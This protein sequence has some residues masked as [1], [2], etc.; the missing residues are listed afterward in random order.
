MLRPLSSKLRLQFSRF[1]RLAILNSGLDPDKD[2]IMEAACIVTEADLSE[3]A[4]LEKI[5][6]HQPSFILNGTQ[7][8]MTSKVVGKVASR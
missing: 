2:T 5:V 4:R 7:F 6:V 3:V 8:A 1:S